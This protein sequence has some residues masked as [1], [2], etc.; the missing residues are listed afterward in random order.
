MTVAYHPRKELQSN[1]LRRTTLRFDPLTPGPLSPRG[2]RGELIR[3]HATMRHPSGGVGNEK[4]ECLFLT[5][6][7]TM[8]LKTKDRENER[9]QTK[10][11]LPVRRLPRRAGE[12]RFFW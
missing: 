1:A 10:P 6:E 7:A 2:A 8:L 3:I 9:S 12:R 4:K 5:N 11:I